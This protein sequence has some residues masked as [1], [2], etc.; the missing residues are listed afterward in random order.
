M[1]MKP[2]DLAPY[3][4]ILVG[5]AIAGTVAWKWVEKRAEV[6]FSGR[7][8]FGQYYEIVPEFSCMGRK[9]IRARLEI[10]KDGEAKLA[11]TNPLDCSEVSA[12]VNLEDLLPLGFDANH[13]GYRGQLF[14]RF[15]K[16]PDLMDGVPEH[17]AI[18][19]RPAKDANFDLYVDEHDEASVVRMQKAKP[20][21]EHFVVG[22]PLELQSHV[23]KSGSTINVAADG[24]TLTLSGE[25]AQ[26]EFTSDGS[27]THVNL[28]CLNEASGEHI[29]PAG[30]KKL[31][32]ICVQE[33]PNA[34][35]AARQD[36]MDACGKLGH[37]FHLVRREEWPETPVT[38]WTRETG[39]TPGPTSASAFRCVFR[40][41]YLQTETILPNDLK[42]TL[43]GPAGP[44]EVG[45][46]FH[47]SVNGFVK[48]IRF[49][50]T[51][52]D[53]AGYTVHLW[54]NKGSALAT[55]TG[56]GQQSNGGWQTIEFKE[57]VAI[58]AKQNFTASYYAAA[59]QVSERI[60]AFQVE[61][62]R[63]L[64]V[65]ALEQGGVSITNGGYPAQVAKDTDFM[66]DVLFEPVK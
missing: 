15:E 12:Q 20:N 8:S 7:P 44:V 30:Y 36:A 3:A 17:T 50:R 23:T 43:E 5:I 29:C 26:A 41:K 34:A 33:M 59:G 21:G 2:S 48:G 11:T 6:T 18:W 49:Y 60:P 35:V 27:K 52:R 45:V 16:V 65:S 22:S 53:A 28:K 63:G 38:E 66:V 57:P 47:A 13:I 4:V 14:Q 1:K 51:Q 64:S 31:A 61:T 39:F 9:Q 42:P 40:E 24:V 56:A 25:A 10:A 62:G 54:D 37:G 19:C 32:E 46:K 55:M 58:A